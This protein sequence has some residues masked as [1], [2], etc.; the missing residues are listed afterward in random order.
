MH[1]VIKRQAPLNK[2]RTIFAIRGFCSIDDSLMRAHTNESQRLLCAVCCGTS[3]GGWEPREQEVGSA[4]SLL[5][6]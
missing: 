1:I 2:S 5:P 3:L 4:P 6:G